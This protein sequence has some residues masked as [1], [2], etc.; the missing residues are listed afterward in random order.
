MIEQNPSI[1]IL[2]RAANELGP[3]LRQIV[4]VG[5]CAVG[6]WISDAATP[7]VRKT[8]DV[9]L[10]VEVA[11]LG[12]YYKFCENLRRLGFHEKIDNH[13][14]CRWFKRDLIIDVMPVKSDVLGFS[15]RWNEL[16]FQNSVEIELP[17]KNRI[18]VISAP[19]LLGTKLES[20]LSR[21]GGDYLHH[22]M[23]DII[24][25]VNGR[26]S[27]QAEIAESDLS[28]KEF[29]VEEIE[30]MLSDPS[31]IDRLS[32]HLEF[33]SHIDR[34]DIVLARLRKIIGL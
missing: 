12:E 33:E 20:F 9:D 14:L 4:L 6:L 26:E 5:G 10:I 1:E 3:L 34:T 19:V 21:G 22:D 16:A 17:S 18:K 25:L 24:N 29:I 27:L 7:P 28:L 13:L 31:F 11:P 23:E 32:W 8:I 15:N 2:E 30:G